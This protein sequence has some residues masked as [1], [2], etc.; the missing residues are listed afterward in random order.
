[1]KSVFLRLIMVRLYQSKNDL[2]LYK[3]NGEDVR[4]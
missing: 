2:K 1:M 3:S 4:V